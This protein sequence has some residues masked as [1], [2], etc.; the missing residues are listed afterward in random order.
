MRMG[1]GNWKTEIP[2]DS[3]LS[4]P[5][6]AIFEP[7]ISFPFSKTGRTIRDDSNMRTV[8]VAVSDSTHSSS[9]FA[10][11]FCVY[12]SGN[13]TNTFSPLFLLLLR[14]I[15]DRFFL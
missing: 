3:V 1:Y 13:V 8:L 11:Y 12:V 5:G 4:R 2:E 6:K 15:P 10:P 9:T 14:C 7:G